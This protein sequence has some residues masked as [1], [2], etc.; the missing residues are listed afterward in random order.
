MVHNALS[1]F[2]YFVLL[3]SQSSSSSS[4][5][6][7]SSSDALNQILD[8]KGAQGIL[9]G[10][11]MLSLFASV[12]KYAI[13]ICLFGLVASLLLYGSG[14]SKNSDNMR[15]GASKASWACY[16]IIMVIYMVIMNFASG[17]QIT[18][19]KGIAVT[20]IVAA[21]YGLFWILPKQ[22]NSAMHV[23]ALYEMS[24]RPDLKQTADKV[25]NISIGSAFL[26]AVLI[27]L[28]IV[29]HSMFG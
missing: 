18:P 19:S 14:S 13:W 29:L 5:S 1:T 15:N 20:V 28:A 9:H 17:G 16:G 3:T 12:Y 23:Y 7:S 11:W 26:A 21:E 24:D 22:Y 25:S 2:N 27:I 8:T 6:S 4:A 10:N